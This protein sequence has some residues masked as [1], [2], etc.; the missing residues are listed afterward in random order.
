MFSGCLA[1][2]WQ[3]HRLLWNK[4]ANLGVILIFGGIFNYYL[5]LSKLKKD[6]KTFSQMSNSNK[7]TSQF[8]FQETSQ[9]APIPIRGN[10]D[11]HVWIYSERWSQNEESQKSSLKE[12][13]REWSLGLTGPKRGYWCHYLLLSIVVICISDCWYP[14]TS[15]TIVISL[16]EVNVKRLGL[17]PNLATRWLW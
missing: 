14:F 16:P 15:L 13:I 6:H 11:K 1:R 12:R 2:K 5:L 10:Q 8:K 17:V 9:L 3:K 4:E 7:L